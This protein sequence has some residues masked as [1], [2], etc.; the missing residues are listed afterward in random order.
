MPEIVSSNGQFEIVRHTHGLCIRTFGTEFCKPEK[1][2]N[3][4]LW[5]ALFCYSDDVLQD[6]IWTENYIDATSGTTNGEKV[7]CFVKDIEHAG[8]CDILFAYNTETSNPDFCDSVVRTHS[9]SDMSNTEI[10]ENIIG[11]AYNRIT[12]YIQ[13]YDMDGFDFPA[14]ENQFLKTC[15][16]VDQTYGASRWYTLWTHTHDHCMMWQYDD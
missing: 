12:L 14:Y 5:F 9:I 7:M 10:I 1:V 6:V 11:G 16:R 15:F 8:M 4:G 13:V 3:E 2:P